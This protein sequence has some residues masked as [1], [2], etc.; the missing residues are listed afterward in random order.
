MS[1]ASDP[2][3]TTAPVAA[4][5]SWL[6][7]AIPTVNGW[8]RQ[9]GGVKVRSGG[10]EQAL[11]DLDGSKETGGNRQRLCGRAAT[12]R[13]QPGSYSGLEDHRCAADHVLMAA[14]LI[15]GKP[16]ER[17][18][19][20]PRRGGERT[21]RHAPNDHRG[22]SPR[23]TLRQEAQSCVNRACLT[24]AG[25]RRVGSDYG[26]GPMHWGSS[27]K[28]FFSR[29]AGS[30]I[31]RGRL[32]SYATSMSRTSAFRVGAGGCRERVVSG[33]RCSG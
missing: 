4:M 8:I 17:T 23:T 28:A 16:P 13:R 9:R 30:A 21:N 1:S 32:A 22:N 24:Q 26:S 19:A 31:C 5:R 2:K 18:S 7:G 27:F 33:C 6:L 14:F 11:S 10:H 3:D 15:G 12:L 25:S 29:S 20:F